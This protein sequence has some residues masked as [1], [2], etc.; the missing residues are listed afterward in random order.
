[1]KSEWYTVADD[2]RGTLRLEFN[3]RM[4]FLHL[5]LRKPMEGLRA[6]RAQFPALKQMLR[7]LGYRKVNVIIE[8]NDEKLYRFEKLFGFRDVLRASG[9][10]LME[11]DC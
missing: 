10:L 7:N 3:R 1:M 4:V 5:I 11:Q 2:E 8:E 9:H 6:V